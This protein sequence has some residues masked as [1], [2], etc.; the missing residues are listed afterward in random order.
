[1]LQRFYKKIVHSGVQSAKNTEEAEKIQ[2]LNQILFFGIILFIPNLIYEYYLHLPLTVVAD[3]CF[4]VVIILSFILN[5]NGLYVWGRNCSIT[6][7]N[8]VLVAGSFLEGSSAGNYLIFI[9]MIILFSMLV[10]LRD[11]NRD[12]FILLIVSALSIIISVTYCPDKSQFQN[13]ADALYSDMYKGN[14]LLAFLL[15]CIFTYINFK[16]N[17]RKEEELIHAKEIAEESSKLKSNFLSNMSHEL[18]TPLNGITGI[19]NLLMLE[20]HLAEQSESLELLK[21]S[22]EHMLSLIDDILDLSKI[23]AGKME[24]ENHPF[25]LHLLAENIYSI[26]KI[27]FESKGIQFFINNKSKRDIEV[28]TDE[29]RLKQILNNLLSNA[30]KFTHKGEV[31][32]SLTVE[33]NNDDTIMANFSVKDSGI[34]IA[35]D[36]LNNIF[37][38]FVQA[39]DNTTKNYG[40]TGLGLTISKKLTE[41]FGGQLQ[42]NSK[43]GEGS[44]FF[45]S[46]ILKR[47]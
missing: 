46:V 21:Y 38:S 33:E 32:F 42:V 10:K 7:A 1:M 14:L 26:F 20:P 13:I 39:D 15:T 30:L 16:I 35:A 12:V 9:P 29:T 2:R 24:M 43:Y 25:N 18:R 27:Q 45:F 22:S 31:V 4:V 19:S 41:I 3:I 28:L 44:T 11:D 6:G 40:G 36:K 17:K 23:E 8:L 47:N 5:K 34:G 37:E